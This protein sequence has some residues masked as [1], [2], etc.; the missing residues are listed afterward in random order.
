MPRTVA[1]L[2][3]SRVE[4]ERASVRLSSQLKIRPGRII[5]R[6]TVA[7]VDDL[8]I[9]QDDADF[10]REKLGRGAHLFVAQ[11]PTQT[12]PT[13]VIELLEEA[14]LGGSERCPHQQW[15]PV[16]DGI[17]VTVSDDKYDEQVDAPRRFG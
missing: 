11:I 3:D 12:S 5:G 9:S 6:D 13:R 8:K 15:A 4:A 17:D 16:E 7:A 14:T 2:Y 1:A 10:Y